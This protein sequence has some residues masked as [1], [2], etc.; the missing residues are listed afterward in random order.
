MA[1]GEKITDEL[2]PR[3]VEESLANMSY[4]EREL[5]RAPMKVTMEVPYEIAKK[6]DESARKN[7]TA[8]EVEAAVLLTAGL[9]SLEITRETIA[10]YGYGVVDREN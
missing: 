7:N 2:D 10:Q 9:R 5:T 3:V 1:R 6:I 4:K 8:Y